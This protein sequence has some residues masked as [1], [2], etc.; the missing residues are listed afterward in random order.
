MDKKIA[1][2]F[3]ALVTPLIGISLSRLGYPYDAGYY[4]ACVWEPSLLAARGMNPFCANEG[5]FNR[6]LEWAGNRF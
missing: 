3:A 2:S 6:F 4:E 5:C 1:L